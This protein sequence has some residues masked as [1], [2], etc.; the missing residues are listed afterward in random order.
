MLGRL[1]YCAEGV[2]NYMPAR[3]LDS[4]DWASGSVII[5]AASAEIEALIISISWT[6]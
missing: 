1:W 5:G 3:S 4:C 6:S 2:T